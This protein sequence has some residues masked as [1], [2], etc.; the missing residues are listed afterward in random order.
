MLNNVLL[1]T[2]VDV[3]FVISTFISIFA[4]CKTFTATN[5]RIIYDIQS[6]RSGKN[7][8]EPTLQLL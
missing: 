1:L 2:F 6:D 7:K 3:L 4:P 8:G 5:I